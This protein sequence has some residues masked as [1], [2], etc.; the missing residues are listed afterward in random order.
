MCQSATTDAQSS[1]Q[2]CLDLL[3]S[4]YS[5]LMARVDGR[6]TMIVGIPIIQS[7]ILNFC[8]VSAHAIS[9]A[10]TILLDLRHMVGAQA[11]WKHYASSN[12]VRMVFQR[13][14]CSQQYLSGWPTIFETIAA[15][16]SIKPERNLRKLNRIGVWS[17]K[18][19]YNYLVILVKLHT[20]MYLIC[21]LL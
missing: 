20:Y 12:S 7:N 16:M 8:L 10:S 9:V 2:A 18:S 13:H 11:P 21:C 6:S 19:H 17:I 4:S 5:L 3:D 15:D 14:K 1:H